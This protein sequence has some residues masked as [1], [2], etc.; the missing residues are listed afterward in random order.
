VSSVMSA[1]ADEHRYFLAAAVVLTLL[2]LWAFSFEYRDLI[3]PGQFTVLVQVHGLVMFAWVGLFL[4]QVALVVW[5]HP[6]WHRRLGVIG[7]G[8]ATLVVALGVPTAI[9]AARL[10]GDHL[11]PGATPAGFLADAFTQ[12]TAFALIA[13][14]GLALRRRPDFHKR[15]MLLAN[16]PPLIA[17]IAR[18]VGFLHLGV[19]VTTLRNLIL[20]ALIA[21]DAIRTRRLHPALVAGGAC[22]IVADVADSAWVGTAVWVGMVHALTA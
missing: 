21:T 18:L 6:L 13:G 1:R 15:L 8:V 20:L 14:S 16:M 5:H 9:T 2:V 22:L 10:G 3:H 12:L 4:T 19:G 11:P 17:V 7:M